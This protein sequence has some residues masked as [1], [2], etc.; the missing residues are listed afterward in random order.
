[1]STS[2]TVEGDAARR[3]RFFTREP[4]IGPG[5]AV[6]AVVED[7]RDLVRAELDLAKAEISNAVQ[8]KAQ[9]AA[10]FAVAAV[11]GWLA[12][13]GLLITAGFALALVVPGW[14][15]ALIVTLVLLLVAGIAALLGRKRLATPLTL[16]ETKRNV[17]EDVAVTRARLSRG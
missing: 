6:K 11:C 8:A 14:L 17:Q 12:L 7:T 1:M 13:Q 3:R 16:D 9:G 10:M 5:A 15:A 4:T 2:S